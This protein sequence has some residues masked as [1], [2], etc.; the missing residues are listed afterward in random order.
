MFRW[1][2]AIVGGAVDVDV[3]VAVGGNGE[4]RWKGGM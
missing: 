2:Q 3:G 1:N 4:K